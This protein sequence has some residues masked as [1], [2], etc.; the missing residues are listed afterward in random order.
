MMAFL[1]NHVAII[2]VALGLC[3]AVWLFGP[4]IIAAIRIRIGG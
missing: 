2:I 4:R 1:L 3:W